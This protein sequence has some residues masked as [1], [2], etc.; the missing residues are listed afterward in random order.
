[1]KTNSQFVG[2]SFVQTQPRSGSAQSTRLYVQAK[3]TEESQVQS[4]TTTTT[5]SNGGEDKESLSAEQADSQ[6]FD[7]V[8][9]IMKDGET[10][11]IPTMLSDQEVLSAYST[12]TTIVKDTTPPAQAAASSLLDVEDA[13]KEKFF[14]K[15][16][17]DAMKE[18]M[19]KTPEELKAMGD[20]LDEDDLARGIR[21]ILEDGNDR[22]I[23]SV[24][25]MREEQVSALM[26]MI[27]TLSCSF[28]AMYLRGF[29]ARRK[30]TLVCP[31]WLLVFS[32][33]Q[34]QTHKLSL[35]HTQT[36][37]HTHTNNAR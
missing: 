6:I 24:Q 7:E 9:S 18:A 26:P 30:Y 33:T 35:S 31:I 15:A 28:V 8:M 37:S 1:M 4:S 2:I 11:D 22:L 32:L 21:K 25:E 14:K 20:P 34:M 12:P 36:V 23:A 19:S 27:W 10:S 16:M 17:A 29:R 13:Q 3:E 5:P